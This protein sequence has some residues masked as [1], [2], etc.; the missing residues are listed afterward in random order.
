MGDRFDELEATLGEVGNL[1]DQLNDLLQQLE[2]M[3]STLNS[4][5]P[6]RVLPD[7]VLEQ[8]QKL[9]VSVHCQL[10]YVISLRGHN[11]HIIQTWRLTIYLISLYHSRY[12]FTH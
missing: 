8:L 11:V 6:S 12:V 4:H 2:K 1:R 7:D 9:A 10:D 5:E 3:R